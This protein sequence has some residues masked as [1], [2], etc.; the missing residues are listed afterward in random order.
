MTW[1]NGISPQAEHGLSEFAITAKMNFATYVCVT[2]FVCVEAVKGER[3]EGRGQEWGIAV[4][5]GYA[6]L[7]SGRSQGHFI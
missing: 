2:S 7:W 5:F 1:F 6:R 3:G 4:R